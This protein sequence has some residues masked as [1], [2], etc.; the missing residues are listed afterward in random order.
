MPNI[1]ANLIPTI[2]QG[3]LIKK[4][5][6]YYLIYFSQKELLYIIFKNPL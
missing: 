6:V 4:S 3:H 1:Y 5:L 2:Q